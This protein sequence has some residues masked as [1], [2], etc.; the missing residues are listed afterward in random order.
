[1]DDGREIFDDDLDEEPSNGKNVPKFKPKKPNV[2]KPVAKPKSI[3]KMLLAA[4]A[5]AKKPKKEVTSLG[6]DD[7]LNDL[8]KE[9]EHPRPATVKMSKG[10]GQVLRTPTSSSNHYTPR[11]LQESSNPRVPLF[12]EEPTSPPKPSHITAKIRSAAAV[13]TE[14]CDRTESK[15]GGLDGEKMKEEKLEMTDM[16]TGM[17]DVP[18]AYDDMP[19]YTADFDDD[20]GDAE[21]IQA[22]SNAE[23]NH[24]VK[25]HI[26]VEASEKP[27]DRRCAMPQ[28]TTELPGDSGW[29]TILG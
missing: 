11:R 12:K 24:D 5:K 29:E 21:A 27:N 26:K 6:D 25:P 17:E 3:N 15:Y 13:K 2:K 14:P 20:L 9:V 28:K 7:R 16:D 22:L 10:K 1:M 8:L 23:K 19:E 4:S 18:A